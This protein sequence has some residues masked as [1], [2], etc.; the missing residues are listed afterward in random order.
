MMA[1][2][3]ESLRL[4]QGRVLRCRWASVE[5]LL[6]LATLR[7][8]LVY[9]PLNTAYQRAAKWPISF[10]M[11][12]PPWWSAPAPTS[13][14][15]A[16]AFQAGTAHVFT[17]ND[18]RT[19]TLLQRADANRVRMPWRRWKRMTRGHHLHQWKQTGRSKGAMLSHANLLSNAQVL[20]DYWDWRTPDQGG[21]VLLHA[22]AHF[23]CM[24]CS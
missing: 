14:G 4:P 18:D 17:L 3:L 15:S 20:K 19:G 7:A 21:E 6:Y 16:V 10:R 5:A 12:S 11:R 23:M 8:G 22:L 2:L 1:N 13:A 24:A 9:L